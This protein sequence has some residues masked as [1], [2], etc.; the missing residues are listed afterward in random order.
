MPE[1]SFLKVI[2]LGIGSVS[3][4]Q[5]TNTCTWPGSGSPLFFIAFLSRAAIVPSEET[6]AEIEEVAQDYTAGRCWGRK[7]GLVGF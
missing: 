1:F 4:G 2:N 5:R 6:E 7:P 3:P